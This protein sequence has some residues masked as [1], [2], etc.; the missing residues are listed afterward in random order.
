MRPSIY[1]TRLSRKN[2]IENIPFLKRWVLSVIEAE[3]RELNRIDIIVCSD[4]YLLKVN[5]DYLQHDYYT[6]IITFDYGKGS[7]LEGEL[8]ISEDRIKEN[9][10]LYGCTFQEEFK[11]VV[12]HGILHLIGYKDKTSGQKRV[13][14]S[15]ENLYLSMEVF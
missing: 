4:S 7:V 5:R 14:R 10:H 15:K 2:K 9:S 6:D 3:K 11:R 12:I 1:L 13:M 8:F